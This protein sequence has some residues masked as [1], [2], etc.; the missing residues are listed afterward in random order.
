M[1]VCDDG[2][3]DLNGSSSSAAELNVMGMVVYVSSTLAIFWDLT[4]EGKAEPATL[5]NL[6][7]G[8][9]RDLR[10]WP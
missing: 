7:W 3:M 9:G 10:G 1:Q 4:W 6:K 5:A 8:T 2:I